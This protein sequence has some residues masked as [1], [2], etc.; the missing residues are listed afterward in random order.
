MSSDGSNNPFIEDILEDREIENNQSNIGPGAAPKTRSNKAIP[1]NL[2]S[3]R[4][5]VRIQ[6]ARP[7]GIVQELA[8][9]FEVNRFSTGTIISKSELAN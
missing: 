4:M 3:Q 6:N 9:A 7:R 5:E 2:R 8:E 1:S